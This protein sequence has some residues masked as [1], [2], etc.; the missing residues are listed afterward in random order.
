MTESSSTPSRPLRHLRVLDLSRMY[1]GA[2]CSLLLADLGADV[3]KIEAPGTGDGLRAMAGPGQ[4]S[5]AHV[6]LN[7]GKRSM[8][9]DL[10]PPAAASVLARLVTRADVVL[11]S[12]RPG[13]LDSLGLGFTAMIVHRPQLVWCSI[14]GFG[15]FGANA[16]QPGHDLTFLGASGLLGRLAAGATP[17]PNITLS[18]PL[19]A[20]MAV[21]GV[22]AAHAEAT[23]EGIGRHLD[24][25][26]TDSAMWV[27]AES[28]VQTAIPVPDWGAM[29]ARNVYRCA[30][31]AEVTVAATEPRTW[32][33][34]CRAVGAPELEAHRMGVDEDAAI[35]RLAAVF[36]TRPAAHWVAE[37]GLAGGVGPVNQPG[38]LLTDPHVTSRGSILHPS[39]TAGPVVANP[40]RFDQ[41]RGEAASAALAPAPDLG[42]DTSDALRAAGFTQEEITEL[43]STGVTGPSSD[44][45]R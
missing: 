43:R 27:M 21:V 30:D 42:A 16:E 37:P 19:A 41:E 8:T 35:E 11:E 40:I 2:Y 13:Q 22:L 44:P 9:L 1:P 17:V 38:Q 36:A 14:T 28:V 26:M 15:D 32:S 45:S 39:G 24:V 3:L 23:R 10:R 7:R 18:I 31:G 6:A 33:T 5:S 29:A 20:L 34:L 12:H 25:N 4:V